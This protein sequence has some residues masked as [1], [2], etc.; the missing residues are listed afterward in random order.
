MDQCDA[1]ESAFLAEHE[2]GPPQLYWV[3]SPHRPAAKPYPSKAIASVALGYEVNGGYGKA[4]SACRVLE[5]A[6]YIITDRNG[7]PIGP[8]AI[9]RAIDKVVDAM[10]TTERDAYIR[11]RVGQD[12]FR[13]ALHQR[14]TCCPLTQISDRVLLRAS[15]IKPWSESKDEERLD[16]NNGL[17][18]SALWDAAF[19]KGL[20]S[21]DATGKAIASPALSENARIELRF[22]DA[23]DLWLDD[24]QEV[25]L[26]WHRAN[27]FKSA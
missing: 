24:G 20:V 22:D 15:H 23:N 6:G 11:A 16:P 2:R 7:V 9:A 1:G 27:V 12:I 18:L 14:W 17:L 21:F 8:T 3:V 10:S 13:D 25:Y 4:T 26:E 5:A 19:D